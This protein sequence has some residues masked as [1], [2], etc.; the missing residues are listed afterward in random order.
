MVVGAAQTVRCA[1]VGAVGG[2]RMDSALSWLLVMGRSH[3]TGW[4]LQTP[5]GKSRSSCELTSG[6]CVCVLCFVACA[7]YAVVPGADE[8]YGNGAGGSSVAAVP[9]MGPDDMGTAGD[10]RDHKKARTGGDM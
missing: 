10:S 9:S 8:P 4:G 7:R 6:T 3:S 1:G 2:G 5:G